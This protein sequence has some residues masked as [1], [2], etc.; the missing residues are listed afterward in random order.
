MQWAGPWFNGLWLVFNSCQS[1]EISWMCIAVRAWRRPPSPSAT[2]ALQTCTT[3]R[4]SWPVCISHLWPSISLSHCFFFLISLAPILHQ[5][6]DSVLL[7]QQ[8]YTPHLPFPNFTA[9]PRSV[10][11]HTLLK[12]NHRCIWFIIVSVDIC[13]FAELVTK[14]L[15][16][17]PIIYQ[18]LASMQ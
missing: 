7:Y 17:I 15:V 13:G 2:P 11:A 14:W 16:Q 18:S 8:S 1:Q 5:P 9:V 6:V 3:S 10:L 12:Y 4:E